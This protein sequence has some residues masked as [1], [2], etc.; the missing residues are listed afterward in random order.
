MQRHI[1]TCHP[2]RE[3]V[4]KGLCSSCYHRQYYQTPRGKTVCRASVDRYQ[5]SAHGQ[6]VLA[7]YKQTPQYRALQ[8]NYA[9]S[10][11]GRLKGR[12]KQSRY[13]QT[14][15]GKSTRA[16]YLQ[17]GKR[18]EV[19]FRYDHSE[20]GR[21]SQVRA[22]QSPKNK[23]RQQRYLKSEK[24]KRSIARKNH[25]R[26]ARKLNGF[27]FRYPH[28]FSTILDMYQHKCVYCQK[29]HLSLEEDHIIPISK[30][31]DDA[32]WNLVPACR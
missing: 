23:I 10:E 27:A 5:Q 12:E 2:D 1:P 4:A 32:W 29:T 11:R 6:A 22:R 16:L 26:R 25:L 19:H 18:K 14:E 17:S 31:G 3:H 9:Q 15:H 24:G 8:K 28:D 30:G 13:L 20:K 21:A 7:P